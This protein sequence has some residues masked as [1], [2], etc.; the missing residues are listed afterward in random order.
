MK[1][2]KNRTNLKITLALSTVIFSLVS[3][4]VGTIAWFSSNTQVMATGCSITVYADDTELSYSIYRFDIDQ[5]YPVYLSD[6]DAT[7]FVL[8]QYDVVFKERNKYNPLYLEISLAGASLG[9]SGSLSFVL[10]RDTSISPMD[11]NNYLSSSFTSVT[12][13]AIGTNSSIQS[14]IY[15]PMNSVNDTWNN[16]N[17]AFFAR[18]SLD[19]LATQSFTSGTSGHY[20]KYDSLT[21]SVNYDSSDFVNGVLYIFLYINYDSTLAENYSN[22]HGISIGGSLNYTLHDDLTT[23]S[24]AK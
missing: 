21:F 13:F 17:A 19:Q 8:N 22:E 6:D 5:N 1:K 14:G 11:A 12:K 24:I 23:L 15:N 18:D 10:Q 3:S 7:G 2:S 4:F 9:S 20:T 16:L